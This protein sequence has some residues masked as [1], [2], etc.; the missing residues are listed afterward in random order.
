MIGDIAHT[1]RGAR[2]ERG[3][4]QSDLAARAGVSRPTVARIESGVNVSTATLV[5]V[6]NALG[7]TLELGQTGR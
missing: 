5:K 6:A 4:S 7:L 1:V 3:W 2:N